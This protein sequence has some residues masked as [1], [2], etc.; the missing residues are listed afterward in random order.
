MDGPKSG[1][2]WT[3]ANG[4]VIPPEELPEVPTR[5]SKGS[6]LGW[7]YRVA[8]GAEVPNE[9]EKEF[10]VVVRCQS[11]WSKSPK[12]VTAQVADITQPLMAVRKMTNA[13]YEVIFDEQ[14]SGALNKITQEWIPMDEEEDAWFLDLWV[15][16]EDQ[17]NE[18]GTGF[19]RQE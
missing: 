18:S 3:G 17:R 19:H 5:E 11:G 15:K 4:T 12:T 8:N 9:G 10:R 7:S 14:G 6:R 1:L 16:S 13:G 2:W